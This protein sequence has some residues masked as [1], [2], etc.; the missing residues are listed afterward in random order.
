LTRHVK[1]LIGKIRHGSDE[2]TPDS[3]S[4]AVYDIIN[5][6]TTISVS[7][8]KLGDGTFATALVVYDDV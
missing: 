6:K 4:K 7:I 3:L 1:V 8:L 5:G 2:T